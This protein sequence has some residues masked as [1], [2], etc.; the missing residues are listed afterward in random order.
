LSTVSDGFRVLLKLFLIIKSYKPLTFFGMGSL[1]LLVLGL[2]VGYRPVYEYITERYVH[3][4]PSAILAASLIVMAFF[5][6]GLGLILNSVNLR[7]LELEKL[8]GKQPSS[9][10]HRQLPSKGPS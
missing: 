10:R 7:L 4:L 2:A 5:S 9:E 1:V 8:I 3:A 6:L